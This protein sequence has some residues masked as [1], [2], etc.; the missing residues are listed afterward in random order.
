[1]PVRGLCYAPP[2]TIGSHSIDA[3]L[4]DLGART[5]TP[6]GGAVAG[7]TLAIGAATGA[8]VVSYSEGK[9]SLAEHAAL[10]EEA[11]LALRDVQR[12]AL[13]L[14][15]EDATAYGHMNEL[16][17]LPADDER[18]RREMPAAVREAIDVPR[19][20]L[21][22]ALDTLRLLRRLVGATNRYLVSD[23]VI[24][25]MVTET[26][27][28]AA[29]CNVRINLPQLEEADEA[30]LIEAETVRSLEEAARV[31]DEV[32]AGRV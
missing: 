23:L 20:C 27:A 19:C 12:T 17:K 18:R 31:R 14:A 3:L 5:P 28:R 11:A 9:K 30:A 10:H 15:E 32:E 24:A 22:A 2:V 8:M 26:A 6:G 16:G 1:M 13:R 29:A 4:A 7:L 25:T 21:N